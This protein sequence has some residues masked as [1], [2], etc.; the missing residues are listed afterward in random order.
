MSFFGD[1]AANQ[2]GFHES[3]NLAALW[4]LPVIYVCEVNQY[5]ESLPVERG[6]PIKD[7]E[8]RAEGYG[9]PGVRVDGLDVKAVY[10]A[11]G[12]LIARARRGDGPSFLVA[13]AYRHEGHYYGDPRKYQTK[14]QIEG[15]KTKFDPLVDARKWIVGEKLAT[16]AELAAIDAQVI[17]E[18]KKAVAFAEAS[19]LASPISLP[20]DVY[21]S[22]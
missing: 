20:G 11:A 4:K 8:K 21:A 1:G 19:P 3:A 6:F 17:E 14:D 18:A 16:E 12:E 9:M 13:Y 15:W 2:G 7:I 22:H 5:A 10:D